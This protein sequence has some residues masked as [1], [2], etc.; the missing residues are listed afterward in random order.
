LSDTKLLGR[1]GEALAAE[2]LRKKGYTVLGLNYRTRLG[3]LDVIASDKRFVVF[4]EVKLR[5]NATFA[6]AREFVT[7]SKQQKVIAAAQEWIQSHPTE[8]Q[9]RFDVMEIYAP[10]GI[11]TAKPVLR[12]LENAYQCD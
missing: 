10:D 5:K 11:A 8:L 3:E 12:H 7:R 2:Y 1:Y 9:P 6:D 4:L